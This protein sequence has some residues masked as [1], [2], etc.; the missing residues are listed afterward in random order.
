MID[1]F[2]QY[3]IVDFLKKSDVPER[4]KKYVQMV[5]TEFG[6]PPMVICS[7]Q[8]GEC[9]SDAWHALTRAK[10]IRN[11][12]PRKN[13]SLVEMARY[14]LLDTRML[15]KYCAAEVNTANYLQNHLS[16]AWNEAGLESS[17]DVWV[18]DVCLD[19]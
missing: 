14:M 2:T 15:L 17:P 18:A 9:W 4:V 16:T 8:G 7:D 3:T 11:S 19:P 5:K 13:C 6:K 10:G 1:D 12:L